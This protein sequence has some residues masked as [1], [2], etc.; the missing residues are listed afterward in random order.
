MRLPMD[1]AGWEQINEQCFAAAKSLA[2]ISPAPRSTYQMKDDL[3]SG[4]TRL[5]AV[6][7]QPIPEW[8]NGKI[9]AIRYVAKR[10]Q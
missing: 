4:L 3:W 10:D 2:A 1:A 9:V 6:H 8:S 5:A 7:L